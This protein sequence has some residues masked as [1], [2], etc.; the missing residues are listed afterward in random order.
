M[1]A[2]E[3][4][5][6]PL[7]LAERVERD[8]IGL[9]AAGDENGLRPGGR[10][11]GGDERRVLRKVLLHR[12][13]AANPGIAFELRAGG[14]ILAL[15]GD[16]IESVAVDLSIHGREHVADDIWFHRVSPLP[17]GVSAIDGEGM[18][19]HETCARAAQPKNGGSNLLR[20]TQPSNRHVSHQLLHGLCLSRYHARNHWWF[21]DPRADRVDAD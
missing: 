6:R 1:I 3:I 15:P 11:R 14:V 17:Y 2:V 10:D 18:A 16:C 8:G 13:A 19:D 20:L 7:Q 12:R 21:D 5:A 4:A 9:C